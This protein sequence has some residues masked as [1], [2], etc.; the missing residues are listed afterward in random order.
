MYPECGMLALVA[1]KA[2]TLLP[3]VSAGRR[4]S[5]WLVLVICS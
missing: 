2:L 4:L 1:F 5:R 3:Q